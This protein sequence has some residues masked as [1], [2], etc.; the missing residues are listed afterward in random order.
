LVRTGFGIS[1]T[2]GATTSFCSSGISSITGSL[3][4][5]SATTTG[6]DSSVKICVLTVE[7]SVIE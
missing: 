5:G 6:F 1:G 3:T 2:I 7:T 4:T